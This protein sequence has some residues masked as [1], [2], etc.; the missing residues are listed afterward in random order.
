MRFVSESKS[1][2]ND[3]QKMCTSEYKK[4]VSLDIFSSLSSAVLEEASGSPGKE[5]RGNL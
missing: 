5:V 2:E 4:K 3:P 1:S